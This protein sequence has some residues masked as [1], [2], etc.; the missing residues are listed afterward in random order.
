VEDLPADVAGSFMFHLVALAHALGLHVTAE[1]V[2]TAEQAAWL[3]AAGCDTAQGW[4]F[5]RPTTWERTRHRLL[6]E[7]PAAR[8]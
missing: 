4:L 6:R 7:L 8:R 5:A 2:E 1:G 3:R